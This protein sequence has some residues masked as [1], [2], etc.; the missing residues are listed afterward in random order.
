V[1][2]SEP[3]LVETDRVLLV[4]DPPGATPRLA[5][6]RLVHL[7]APSERLVV[8]PMDA[9]EPLTAVIHDAVLVLVVRPDAPVFARSCCVEARLEDARWLVLYPTAE[10]RRLERRLVE[11]TVVTVPAEGRRYMRTGGGLAVRGTV[12]DLSMTG[13]RF[14]C[15]MAAALG[16][17]LVLDVRAP[18]DEV[19]HLRGQVVRIVH[20]Q[21]SPRALWEAGCQFW[22]VPLADQER[23]ARFVSGSSGSV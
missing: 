8:T 16:D 9:N 19:L 3:V 21:S 4:P 18:G 20:P 10:W 6:C 5:E 15:D 7:D 11:R 14:E 17:L 23:I 13:F 22:G 2:S 12:R 1:S